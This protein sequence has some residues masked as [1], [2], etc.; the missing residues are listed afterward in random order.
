MLF[1]FF[2]SNLIKFKTFTLCRHEVLLFI[3]YATICL[4]S[5]DIFMESSEEKDCLSF[6]L[7]TS[8]IQNLKKGL[9]NLPTVTLVCMTYNTTKIWLLKQFNNG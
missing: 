7:M 6:R 1:I 8:E 3:D 9:R 5:M 2:Y 4:H